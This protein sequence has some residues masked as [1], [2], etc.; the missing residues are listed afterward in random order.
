MI[1]AFVNDAQDQN[2]EESM[3]RT[4]TCLILLFL[5][6]LPAYAAVPVPEPGILP[7][8]VVGGVVGLALYLKRRK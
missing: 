4:F 3:K 6:P 8:L 2:K 1:I 5:A 7:M